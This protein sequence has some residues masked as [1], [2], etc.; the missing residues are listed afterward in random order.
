MSAI[1]DSFISSSYWTEKI[2][3]AAALATIK[4]M[5]QI[6][7]YDHCRYMGNK[8]RAVWND[9]GK[10]HGLKVEASPLVT[11]PSFGML[12]DAETSRT[13]RS[14]WKQEMLK[15]GIL[16]NC[17]FMMMWT[18]KVMFGLFLSSSPIFRDPPRVLREFMP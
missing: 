4:K 10:K 14:L 11:W 15:L 13:L 9:T 1:H 16:A 17:Q 6:P 12:Y 3:P 2:G 18:F 7:V 8:V 5:E